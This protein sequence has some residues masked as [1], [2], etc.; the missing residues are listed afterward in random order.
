MAEGIRSYEH[1]SGR[2]LHQDDLVATLREIEM[3]PLAS[4]YLPKVID[5]IEGL[6]RAKE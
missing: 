6:G 4:L 5:Y 1:G 3:D 2:Y